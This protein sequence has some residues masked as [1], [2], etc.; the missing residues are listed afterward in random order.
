MSATTEATITEVKPWGDYVTF[1]PEGKG[2][3]IDDAMPYEA[4]AAAIKNI[5]SMVFDGLWALGDLLNF[6]EDHYGEEHSQLL[7]AVKYSAKTQANAMWV[8]RAFAPSRRH[9]A[10]TFNHHSVVASIE[11]K[12]AR[13]EILKEAEEKNLSVKE[14]TEIKKAKFP[15][16]RKKAS[17]SSQD[18]S[19]ST[20]ASQAAK[21][22]ARTEITL[23]EAISAQKTL[24]A[25][26]EFQKGVGKKAPALGVSFGEN[27][28]SIGKV[29][30]SIGFFGGNRSGKKK[31]A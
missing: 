29:G 26:L 31:K 27:M 28:A 23:L 13:E 22:Q 2:L 8:C 10:L 25:F 16:K 21:D 7:D 18:A 15:S 14:I 3:K 5:S 11:D 19:G 12:E 9:K 1:L 6:A 30:R 20:K 17:K 24:I 4:C